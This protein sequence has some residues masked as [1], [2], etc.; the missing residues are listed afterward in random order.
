MRKHL[1]EAEVLQIVQEYKKGLGCR[2]IASKLNINSDIVRAVLRGR[3]YKSI[4][5]GRIMKGRRTVDKSCH[6]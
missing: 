4:T 6:A 3:N 2:T 1:S 5:G